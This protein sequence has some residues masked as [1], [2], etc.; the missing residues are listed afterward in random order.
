MPFLY[1]MYNVKL[2]MDAKGLAW[3]RGGGG[4]ALQKSLST[5]YMLKSQ[6][7]VLNPYVVVG[8]N[9]LRPINNLSVIK[10]RTLC[11]NW[12]FSYEKS[13]FVDN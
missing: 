1:V 6:N 7:R 5:S 4:G 2:Q 13:V 3:S 8:S 9:S 10:G 11:L 12:Y